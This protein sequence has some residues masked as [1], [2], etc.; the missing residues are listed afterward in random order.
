MTTNSPGHGLSARSQATVLM[1]ACISGLM[2]MERTISFAGDGTSPAKVT[3]TTADPSTSKPVEKNSSPKKLETEKRVKHA[4][5]VPIVLDQSDEAIEKRLYEDVSYLAS[6]ELEGRGVR[7][8]GLVLAS[9]YI[10][11]SFRKSGLVTDWYGGPF[12]EF[13]LFSST[14]RGIV[15]SSELVLPGQSNPQK[16]VKGEDYSSLS[17]SS[18]GNFSFPIIFAGYG[19]TAHD[20]NYDDYATI[21]AKGKAVLILR[22]E[23]QRHDEKSVFNGTANSPHAYLQTKIKNAVAH[24]AA[25][26]IL[27]TDHAEAEVP[28]S[29]QPVPGTEDQSHNLEALLQTDLPAAPV[30][31]GIPVIH[32]RR[33]LVEKLFQ[34]TLSENL[35]E[36]ENRI[37]LQF[38]PQSREIPKLALSGRVELVRP[39]RKLRNVVASLEGEGPAAEQTIIVGAH[40]DHLGRDSYGSLANE[41]TDEIH[42]GADDNA[43]GTSVVLEVARQLAARPEPLKHRVLFITFSAEE[44]GL[45]GSSRYVQDPLI[46]LS[47]TMVML[48]LDM[49]GRLRNGNLTIYGVETGENWKT[50][51]SAGIAAAPE[52]N[53]FKLALRS[54]GYGPSDH[55]S[56]FEKGVPV[57][58]FFT[59]FHPQYHRPSD[60]ASLINAK[61]MRQIAGLMAAMVVKLGNDEVTIKRRNSRSLEDDWDDELDM[62]LADDSPPPVRLGIEVGV[63]KDISG[64]IV[65]AV[66]PDSLADRNG[67]RI[68]D[69]IVRVDDQAVKSAQEIRAALQTRRESPTW[70]L[71]L[72]RGGIDAEII[73]R[74]TPVP[75]AKP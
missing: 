1:L 46:P 21:D 60:V 43:S 26:M 25:A 41:A 55:A 63:E 71:G 52:G 3:T 73:V 66:L 37:D 68:G 4:R 61:G 15:Q 40:Y 30:P 57:L 54:G 62:E 39:N 19:I 48:N 28:E 32:L 14:Q 11:E 74:R 17:S 16:L 5:H 27:C 33:A 72:K 35:A 56:F 2:P 67:V 22:H 31:G 13:R 7:T 49:V 29:G 53:Q 50:L 36:L 9:E 10:A 59:G 69:V 24:G 23:P 64:A 42:H 20:L 18:Q 58:H 45:I 38:K 44:L 70:K 51:I 34:D 47:Q 65:R 75:S 12:H 6:D 8:K